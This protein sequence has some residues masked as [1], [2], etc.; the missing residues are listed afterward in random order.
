MIKKLFSFVLISLIAGCGSIGSSSAP[1]ESFVA[2]VAY[3]DVFE[4]AKA[5]ANY[6]WRTE[7]D[8]P[9]VAKMNETDQSLE[10]FVTGIFGST[11]MAEVSGRASGAGKTDVRIVVSGD[12]IWNRA[13]VSAMKDAIVFGVPSCTSYMPTKD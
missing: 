10:V 11:R 6:C 9:I 8:F 3:K 2:Q 7:S 5:Q 4:R 12:S 13:A 1:Q